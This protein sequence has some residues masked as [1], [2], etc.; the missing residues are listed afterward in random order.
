MDPNAF[1]TPRLP[2]GPVVGCGV[3]KHFP[4]VSRPDANADAKP[5]ADANT[6]PDADADTNPDADANPITF[7]D[8]DTVGRED[9]D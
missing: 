8:A 6:N 1:T 9:H 3:R 5:D 4:D 7:T 2:R